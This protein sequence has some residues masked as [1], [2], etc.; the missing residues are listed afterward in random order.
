M[1]TLN[2][3]AAAA[4]HAQAVA[5]TPAGYR[6]DTYASSTGFAIATLTRASGAGHV[7]SFRG[8]PAAVLAQIEAQRA[9]LA[10]ISR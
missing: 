7:V 8:T 9:A 3:P 5:A 1:Q 2:T 6:A 4:F 10:Q